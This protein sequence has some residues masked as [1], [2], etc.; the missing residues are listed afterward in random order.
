M[1]LKRRVSITR[2]GLLLLLAASIMASAYA[3]AVPLPKAL[4]AITSDDL[5]M[6]EAIQIAQSVA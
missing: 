6:N 5:S 1:K 3:D 2:V 4:S